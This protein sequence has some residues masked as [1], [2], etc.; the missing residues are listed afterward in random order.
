MYDPICAPNFDFIELS[1]DSKGLGGRLNRYKLTQ[2]R[3]RHYDLRKYRGLLI[4][5]VL[6]PIPI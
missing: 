2:H 4:P 3:R 5:T 1:D 6:Y